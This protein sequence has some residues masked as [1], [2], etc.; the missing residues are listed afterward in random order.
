MARR[1]KQDLKRELGEAVRRWQVEQDVFDDEVAAFL[2]INRTDARVLDLVDR[3]GPA[4]AGRLA[5]LAHL[6]PAAMTTALDRLERSGYVRRRRDAADR[7]RVLVEMT[8]RG[9]RRTWEVFGPLVEA[10][11]RELERLSAAELEAVIRFLRLVS[12]FNARQLERVK[13]LR[14]GGGARRRGSGPG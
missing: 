4:T 8:E 7:R 12:G 1:P 3:E 6:S 14:H 5:E 13:R 9:R 11:D 2:G 10:S